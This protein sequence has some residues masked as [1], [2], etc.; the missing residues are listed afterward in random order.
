[1]RRLFALLVMFSCLVSCLLNCSEGG[2]GQV[3]TTDSSHDTADTADTGAG[4]QRC[5]DLFTC[6]ATACS[7]APPPGPKPAPPPPPRPPPRLPDAA[8]IGCLADCAA[9]VYGPERAAALALGGCAKERC[10]QPT[11]EPGAP[12]NRCLEACLWGEC[13]AELGACGR[14]P[15]AGAGRCFAGLRCAEALP[16][17]G[18]QGALLRCLAGQRAS[19]AKLLEAAITCFELRGPDSAE[20]QSPAEQ[21]AC[22]AD[23]G[24]GEPYLP[25]SSACLAVL[26]DCHLSG[27][28]GRAA[29]R[30]SLPAASRQVAEPLL[31][32]IAKQ[33]ANCADGDCQTKCAQKKCAASL[34]PCLLDRCDADRGVSGQ[35]DC[36][37]GMKCI[38]ACGGS[39]N[40]CC[41]SLCAA[42]MSGP[43]KD[44]ATQLLDCALS[45]CS[46]LSSAALGACIQGCAA[47]DGQ[48]KQCETPRAHD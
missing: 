44:A 3:A 43:A 31:G 42:S 8:E 30:A 18:D 39:S 29:C 12:A 24:P 35:G 21:C 28:C 1:M 11:C 36:A 19:S 40:P 45:E 2:A 14:G 33:C 34:A 23:T 26:A 16:P 22:D 7:P 27:P 5:P 6:M 10:A 4:G 9:E 48:R 20:C 38:G 46:C 37:S 15:V 13:A 25:Q 47:C 41:L 32:C 17:G